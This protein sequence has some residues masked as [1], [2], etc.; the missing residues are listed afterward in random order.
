MKFVTANP[1]K[2]I[3]FQTAIPNLEKLDIDLA[4]I[5][6]KDPK[7][8]TEHKL[9]EGANLIEGDFFCEDTSLELESM[10]GY[11]GPFIKWFAKGLEYQHFYDICKSKNNFNVTARTI[12]GLR[13]NNQNHF[14][15]GSVKGTI[16]PPKGE[17]FGF[18]VIFKPEGS[19]KRF[20]EMT[21][22]EKLAVSHRGN[23]IRK[24]KN[25]YTNLN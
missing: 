19:D 23:A 17:A 10:N 21:R 22:E 24:L 11:P 4:E 14:L 20:S 18:D 16:V 15:E 7:K 8:V 5:Q 2:L 1:N 12:I 9:N 13:H 6:D 3:E 25:F